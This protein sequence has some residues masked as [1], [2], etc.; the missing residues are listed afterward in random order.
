VTTRR[1]RPSW[2]NPQVVRTHTAALTR[3]MKVIRDPAMRTAL[4]GAFLREQPVDEVVATL[5]ELVGEVRRSR[6]PAEHALADALTV[7]LGDHAA[8]SYEVRTQL[9]AAAKTAGYSEVARL[10]FDASPA[11][12]RND[13]ARILSPERQ[14][15][16]RGR[17]LTLGERKALAR[18]NRRDLILHVVRDPHPDV[19]GVL[20]DNPHVTESDVVSITA[21]RAAH[22]DTLAAVAAHA[23]WRVRHAIK[24]ALVMNPATPVHVAVRLLVTLRESDLREIAGDPHLPEELRA[25][26][27]AL[28]SSA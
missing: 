24:R 20:L 9:Y 21:N 23:R 26:A 4:A 15:V 18:T 1:T 3:K 22:P 27:M 11:T 8:V 13:L 14:V 12:E 10:L 7:A 19:A 2:Q 16:P 25:Q 5:H 28:S 17:I 6:D